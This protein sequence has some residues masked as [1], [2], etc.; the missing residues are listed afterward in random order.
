MNTE[1]EDEDNT[2]V[3]TEHCC[4][5]HGCR[6]GNRDGKCTVVSGE[7]KQSFP[8]ED[9]DHDQAM[10]EH[11]GRDPAMIALARHYVGPGNDAHGRLRARGLIPDEDHA[12]WLEGLKLAQLVL[13]DED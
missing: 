12:I 6:Y 10:R 13:A 4:L 8:C 7:K 3:H 9:C 1:P 11:Y 5:R 2:D